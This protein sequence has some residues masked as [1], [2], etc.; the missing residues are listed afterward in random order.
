MNNIQFW[1]P[2]IKSS[3][4]LTDNPDVYRS[5]GFIRIINI[6]HEPYEVNINANGNGFHVIFGSQINGNFLCIP[7]WNLG[8]ELG[9]YKE[10]IRNTDSIY[11]TGQVRYEDACAISNAL[12]LL[13]IML[14]K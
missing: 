3:D 6:K 4:L 14:G 10:R 12:Q 5:Q 8:C 1:Y 11:G 2:A 9:P 13:E 7:N